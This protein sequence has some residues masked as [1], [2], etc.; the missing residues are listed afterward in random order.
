MNP[1]RRSPGAALRACCTAALLGVA[2]AQGGCAATGADV[3]PGPRSA[4]STVRVRDPGGQS[5]QVELTRDSHAHSARLTVTPDQAWSA[6]RDVYAELGIPVVN[7]DDSARRLGNP[8]LRA[9]RSLAGARLSQ[10]VRCGTTSGMPNSDSYAVTLAVAT[11]VQQ[12]QNGGALVLT[13]VDGSA[14]PSGIGASQVPCTTTGGL[15]RRIAEALADRLVSA[16]T[17]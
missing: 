10:L 12:D 9:R 2:A 6:L 8:A 7:V 13:Q 11:Q 4:T 15:E 1:F 16:S 5:S 14:Q 3:A 17:P